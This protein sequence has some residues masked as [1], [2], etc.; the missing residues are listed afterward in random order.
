M[1]LAAVEKTFLWFLLYSFV[2][3]V[4]ETG[5]NIVMKKRF[6]DRGILNGPICPIYGFGAA[7]AIFVLHDEHSLI[8]VFLS[9]GVL[10]CT[11][12]YLTSWGI[13]K[14]FH[15]RLW[16]Y[17]NK[18]FNINGRVYLNGFLFFAA[19]CTVVKEWVQPAVM[20]VLDRFDPL[21]LNIVS[22]TL[23]VVLMADVAVTL[24]GLVSMNGKL[25]RAEEYI[26]SVKKEQI[27]KMD[28]HITA[29]DERIEQIEQRAQGAADRVKETVA[30]TQVAE[31]VS[32]GV[33]SA[34]TRGAE[35][36]AKLHDNF[37]WQQRRLID[38]YP[39]M[40]PERGRSVLSEIRAQL[41]KYGRKHNA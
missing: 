5:L 13:E 17:S 19:G 20:R 30:R 36:S 34:K 12:E 24:A 4:W 33:E 27:A 41:A 32:G 37:N 9:S 18:P 15:M 26:K 31:R 28:V 6:V 2:G 3:W 11:L 25:G 23:F 29:A 21:W 22:I 8:A 40:K 7:L 38:A 14:L 10:A 35:L 16:D 39:E 1:W